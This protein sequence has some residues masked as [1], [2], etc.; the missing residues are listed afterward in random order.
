MFVSM[1]IGA[2]PRMGKTFTLR[3]LLLIAAH[4]PARRAA[5]L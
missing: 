5:R 4:G 3:E 2:V 1:V